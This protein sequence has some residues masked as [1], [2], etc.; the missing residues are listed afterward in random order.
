[1][2][3]LQTLKMYTSPVLYQ[4]FGDIIIFERIKPHIRPVLLG[5]ETLVEHVF[6][7]SHKCNG[8][9]TE[10]KQHCSVRVVAIRTL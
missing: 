3:A 7:V 4:R 2:A 5:D 9:Q 8:S 1:M 10:A 6:I